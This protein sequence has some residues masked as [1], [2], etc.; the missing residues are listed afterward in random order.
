MQFDHDKLDVLLNT[1]EGNGKRLRPS[2]AKSFDDA[3]SN[4][5]Y[6]FEP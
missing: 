1:A 3:T 4:V 5:S 6:I 2:R